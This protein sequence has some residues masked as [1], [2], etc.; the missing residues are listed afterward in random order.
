MIIGSLIG[1]RVSYNLL[2]SCMEY[3]IIGSLSPN[4]FDDG[5]RYYSMCGIRALDCRRD[6]NG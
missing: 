6:A 2:V 1:K 4:L 3:C 5:V